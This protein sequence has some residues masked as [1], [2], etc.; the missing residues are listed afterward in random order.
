ML[1]PEYQ[2][3]FLRETVHSPRIR[4]RRQVVATRDAIY[5]FPSIFDSTIS[6]SSTS[7]EYQSTIDNILILGPTD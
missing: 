7:R 2:S 3:G 6:A 4:F 1:C 5:F